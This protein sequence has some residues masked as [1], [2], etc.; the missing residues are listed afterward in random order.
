MSIY[1]SK[2]TNGFYDSEIHATMPGDVVEISREDHQSLL[3]EQAS[4]KQITANSAGYPVAM[5][6]VVSD[7]IKLAACKSKAIN[8]LSETDWTQVS[9]CPLKNKQEFSEYRNKVRAL[10]LNPVVSPVF[11]SKPEEQW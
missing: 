3:T 7:D 6:S 2:T 9:D 4:G 5:E 8:L 1:F 10:A 11:P